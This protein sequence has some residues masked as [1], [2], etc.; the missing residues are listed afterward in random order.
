[1]NGTTAP[2]VNG[3]TNGPQLVTGDGAVRDGYGYPQNFQQ[4]VVGGVS[5]PPRPRLQQQPQVF[6]PTVESKGKYACP[7][8]ARRFN[9]K[10]DCSDHKAR[11][12][13]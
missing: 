3:Y 2:Y 9:S 4:L 11:C 8:C 13:S 5:Q 10:A 12:M 6:V 1:M 7:R